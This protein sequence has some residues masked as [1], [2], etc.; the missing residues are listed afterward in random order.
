MDKK[1]KKQKKQK[2]K[3][4][5]LSIVDLT[6]QSLGLKE[7]PD[8]MTSEHYFLASRITSGQLFG[9]TFIPSPPS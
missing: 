1:K 4:R 2:K 5:Q 9:D 8:P 7:V 6:I 3:L